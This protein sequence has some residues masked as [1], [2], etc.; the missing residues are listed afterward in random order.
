MKIISSICLVMLACLASSG[1]GRT[2]KFD[3]L[4]LS[5][6]VTYD[7]QPVPFGS[8]WF[9]PRAA[10]GQLAPP[11]FAIIRDGHFETTR[12][13]A[14]V[15]GPH[16]IRISGYPDEKPQDEDEAERQ[17]LFP[18]YTMEMELS[19]AETVLN[20]DVPRRKTGSSGR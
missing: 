7:G 19:P 14:P 16:L 18:E 4:V 6:Q 1:C 11:G 9:E 15:A 2:D 10:V 20:V 13:D 12:R 8:I 3:R 5:G 17:I